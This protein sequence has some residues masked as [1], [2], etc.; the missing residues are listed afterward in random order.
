VNSLLNKNIIA[1]LDLGS[2]TFRIAVLRCGHGN[3]EVLASETRHVRLGEG[4]YKTGR[5]CNQAI[6]RGIEALREFRAIMEFNKV[7]AFRACGTAA[8]RQPENSSSFLKKAEELG[9]PVE[10][11]SEKEEADIAAKGVYAS[12]SKPK[13]SFLILDVGGGSTELSLVRDGI[14]IFSKSFPLGA[15]N[16]YESHIKNDPPKKEELESMRCSINEDLKDIESFFPAK[17][18]QI[19]GIG[20]ACTTTG[21]VFLSMETYDP[22]RIRGMEIPQKELEDELKRLCF[23]NLSQR[24]NL[25]GLLPERADIIISGLALLLEILHILGIKKITLTDGGLLLGL[26]VSLLEKE[27]ANYVEPSHIRGIYL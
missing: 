16:L 5:L 15:V 27:F 25:P 10:V 23:L 1:A 18:C 22:S 21:A 19:V 11:I 26:V 2:Q 17:P 6:Q 24:K 4:L 9:I 14:I 13:D 20:G 12:L 7:D 3:L 8:L